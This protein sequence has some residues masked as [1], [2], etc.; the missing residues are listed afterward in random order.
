MSK[1]KSPIAEFEALPESEKQRIAAELSRP[2]L[3]TSPLTPNMKK[4]W[5]R[6][7]KKFGRP[8]KGL[9]S[10]AI[11]VTVEKGLLA[12]ADA[13]AK[14]SGMTRAQMIAQGLERVMNK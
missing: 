12:R 9:G 8:V 13:Y 7:K 11:N 4:Q 14:A 6:I 10:K 5:A 1:R 2:D 3:P